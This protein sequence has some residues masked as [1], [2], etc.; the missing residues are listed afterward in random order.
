LIATRVPAAE[1]P[2]FFAR[3][4]NAV[5]LMLA[6]LLAIGAIAPRFRQR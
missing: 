5:P 3:F 6:L 2:T 1:P 4:G